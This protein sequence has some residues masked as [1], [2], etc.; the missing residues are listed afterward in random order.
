M[1]VLVQ[2]PQQLVEAIPM[3]LRFEPENSIVVAG[4]EG[5]MTARVDLPT[6]PEETNAVA[7]ELARAYSQFPSGTA[8]IA[9]YDADAKQAQQ[10]SAAVAKALESTRVRVVDRIAVNDDIWCQLDTGRRGHRD[11]QTETN[12]RASFA[13][14]GGQ[15]APLSSRA[16][17]AESFNLDAEAA[18]PIADLI[19][20]MPDKFTQRPQ[21]N[22][23]PLEQRAV[24][25]ALEQLEDFR[26]T[27][28]PLDEP[29]AAR[30]IVILARDDVS[31]AMQ[32][33]MD[34]RHSVLD[35]AMFKDLLR[36]TPTGLEQPVAGFAALGAYLA[37]DGAAA[38]SALDRATKD[39]HHTGDLS[40]LA[41]VVA[42]ALREAVDPKVYEK[43]MQAAV[44]EDTPT[45]DSR[46]P[47]REPAPL[48][49]IQ[50]RPITPGR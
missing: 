20:K 16:A 29:D 19:A 37:G 2:N 12:I 42:I 34:A 10:I 17:L 40:G 39:A 30:M 9:I 31:N 35:A 28:I 41:G 22:E 26:H 38:W 15:V 24:G 4:F 5:C 36:R 45:L 49:P 44:L 8:A 1:S 6:N 3:M 46:P 18:A 32:M 50:A 47:R 33:R 25:W 21:E 14:N 43:A 13:L 23:L 7:R 48:T 11:P 27:Q